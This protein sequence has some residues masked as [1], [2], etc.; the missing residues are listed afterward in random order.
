[1][2]SYDGAESSELVGAYLLHKIKEK[3]GSMCDFGLYQN[4]DLGISKAS[5]R[6][7]ELKKK[8]ICAVFSVVMA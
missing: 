7:I 6:Q 2:G 5:P 4:D 1:M 3:F 8:K